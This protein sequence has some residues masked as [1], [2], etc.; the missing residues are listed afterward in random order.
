MSGLLESLRPVSG[1]GSADFFIT[2][3]AIF[4]I[5]WYN[6]GYYVTGG[7]TQG[8]IKRAVMRCEKAHSERKEELM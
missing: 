7:H 2:L 6:A 3:I 4:S 5:L 1:I 8:A